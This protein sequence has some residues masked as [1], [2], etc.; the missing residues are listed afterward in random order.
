VNDVAMLF[1]AFLPGVPLP[2]AQQQPNFPKDTCFPLLLNAGFLTTYFV[3]GS[4]Y[5]TPKKY[6]VIRVHNAVRRSCLLRGVA[7]VV[8]GYT[9]GNRLQASSTAPVSSIL[10]PISRAVS[11]GDGSSVRASP[12]P[13]PP[14][15]RWQYW[16]LAVPCSVTLAASRS[17][18][19]RPSNPEPAHCNH[20]A[21]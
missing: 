8:Q 2:G 15:H 17:N 1:D 14:P 9:L 13:S 20:R 5:G 19:S 12:P 10:L 4:L 7:K 6:Q 18:T 3:A 16:A 11:K 21:R